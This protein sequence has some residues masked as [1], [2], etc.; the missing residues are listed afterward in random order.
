MFFGGRGGEYKGGVFE[1]FF[2]F[3]RKLKLRLYLKTLKMRL[4]LNETFILIPFYMLS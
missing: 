2:F 1:I 3:E 4:C